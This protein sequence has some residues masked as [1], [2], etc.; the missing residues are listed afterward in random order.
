VEHGVSIWRSK[1]FA[2]LTAGFANRVFARDPHAG[3][4]PVTVSVPGAA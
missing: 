4:P 1:E 3:E 2:E